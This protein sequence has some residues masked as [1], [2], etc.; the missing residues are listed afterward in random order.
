M[1]ILLD[2]LKKIRYWALGLRSVYPCCYISQVILFHCA[3]SDL[4]FERA[5]AV[6]PTC[7]A[8]GVFEPESG[9]EG[10]NQGMIYSFIVY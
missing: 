5:D 8:S 7:H 10:L 6:L 1:R 9:Q 4:G 2:T 3:P